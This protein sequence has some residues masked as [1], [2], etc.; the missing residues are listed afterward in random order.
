MSKTREERSVMKALTRFKRRLEASGPGLTV[1][2]IALVVAL[3]G[4]AFAA[5][6]G[7]T[8][9]QKKQVESIAKKLGPP[10]P[11]GATGPA[12]PTGPAGAKGDAGQQ[13]K[14]GQQGKDGAKGEEGEGVGLTTI[15]TGTATCDE[16]GGVEVK[17]KKAPT[18]LPVCN[19]EDGIEGKEGKAGSPWAV[20]GVLPAGATETGTFAL[21]GTTADTG[22]IRVPIPFAVPL[23]GV[24]DA[25]QVHW[26]TGAAPKECKNKE[27]KVANAANPA[28]KPGELCVFLSTGGLSETEFSGIFKIGAGASESG[29]N[30][31]GAMATFTAPTG[32]ALGYGSFAV[33]APNPIVTSVSPAQGPAAGG[34]AVTITGENLKHASS[35]KFGTT[36]ATE[37][38]VNETGTQITC[39]TPPHGVEELDVTVTVSGYTSP[40]TPADH[41]TFQ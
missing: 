31:A 32:N 26:V 30:R 19:G 41:F 22:G 21:T 29:A 13:G 14:E 8:K 27:E 37:V 10:G 9:T 39:I 40:L 6:G 1:A 38:V 15:P 23:N 16:R 18:G 2:V 20:G 35:V 24:Y 7:L 17:L 33:T 28:A 4:G 34:T 36:S 5:S 25:T 11:P 3:S 12:G